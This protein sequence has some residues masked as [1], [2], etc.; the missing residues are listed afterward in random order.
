MTQKPQERLSRLE[1]KN[2]VEGLKWQ[3]D[4]QNSLSAF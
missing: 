2:K 4:H 1:I 3:K